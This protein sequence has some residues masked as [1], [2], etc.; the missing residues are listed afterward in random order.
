MPP[1]QEFNEIYQD[2]R[3]FYANSGDLASAILPF[4]AHTND[5]QLAATMLHTQIQTYDNILPES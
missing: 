5:F 1:K 2:L 3:R 4:V